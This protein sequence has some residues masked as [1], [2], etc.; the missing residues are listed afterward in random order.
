MSGIAKAV[1]SIFAIWQMAGW[2]ATMSCTEVEY[3]KLR[4]PRYPQEA[5]KDHATGKAILHVMVG[6]DGVP[7]DI[8]IVTSTGN[9]YLDNAAV[10]SAAEWRFKPKRCSGKAVS[11]EVLLP[12]NFSLADSEPNA[13]WTVKLDTEPMEF[14]TVKAELA[15][16]RGEKSLEEHSHAYVHTYF[17]PMTTRSWLVIKSPLGSHAVIRMREEG[18]GKTYGALYAYLCDGSE[19]WCSETVNKQ[20]SFLKANPAPPPPTTG[21]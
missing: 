12:V 18:N 4:P 19:N 17:K 9:V 1:A 20:I 7:K 8:R 3:A 16:L 14:S 15:F 2:S 6:A 11:S 10:E 5:V 21:E 13:S